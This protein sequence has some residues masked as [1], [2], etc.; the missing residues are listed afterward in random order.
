M[1]FARENRA[2]GAATM[3]IHNWQARVSDADARRRAAGRRKFNEKR[4]Q[5]AYQRRDQVQQ[6]WLEQG[7]TWG[8]QTRLARQ[9]GVHKSTISRDVTAIRGAFGL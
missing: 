1:R 3:H 9:L 5:A 2:T 7:E 4:R 8:W 6:A